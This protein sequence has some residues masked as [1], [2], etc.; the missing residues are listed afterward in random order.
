MC[1]SLM[2]KHVLDDIFFVR[3]HG[4]GRRVDQV[5]GDEDD[6][7]GHGVDEETVFRAPGGH[8]DARKGRADDFGQVEDG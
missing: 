2:P 4:L 7:V 3:C 6:D 1:E 5:K 8:D